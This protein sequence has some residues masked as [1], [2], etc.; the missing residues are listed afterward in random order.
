MSMHRLG[1]TRSRHA[2]DHLLQTPD[3]FVWAPLPGMQRATACVHA[4]P[5]L[6]A[7][8]TQCTVMLEAGGT[9]APT[10]LERFVYVL[11]GTLELSTGDQHATLG[12]GGYAYIPPDSQSMLTAENSARAVVI[13]RTYLPLQGTSAP[14]LLI[15]SE[16]SIQGLPLNG[17]D[18]L[19]VRALLPPDDQA[20]DFA[21]NT[22]EFEPGAS[23]SMV[24]VHVMEHGLLMLEG[25]G[26]YRLG[27][28][29]YP[30]QAGDFIWMGPYCPQWFGA[31]GKTPS[32]YLIYKNWNRHPAEEAR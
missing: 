2:H 28:A 17:D 26:I 15:G 11:E 9:I 22:M 23:L 3:T 1:E 20:F 30:V 25:G 16:G 32:K 7:G 4:A 27:N 10:F 29:W 5:S 14:E 31:L 21:V 6:G 12:V 19:Q 8:F 18:A 13:E 24:E